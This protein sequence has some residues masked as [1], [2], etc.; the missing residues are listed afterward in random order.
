MRR[1]HR[2]A[3]GLRHAFKEEIEPRFPVAFAANSVKSQELFS[4]EWHVAQEAQQFLLEAARRLPVE[5]IL[6]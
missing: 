5:R 6:Q 3:G 4:G 2:R 1:I